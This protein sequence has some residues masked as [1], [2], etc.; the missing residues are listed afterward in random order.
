MLTFVDTGV[1]YAS[2]VPSDPRHADVMSWHQ[3]NNWP[4]VT[5]DYV[6]DETLTLLRARG[7]RTRADRLGRYFFDLSGVAIEFLAESD[8]R[9]A[10]EIFHQF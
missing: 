9:R 2:V 10:W 4:L 3:S 8:I 5:T 1:W 6:I 7:E